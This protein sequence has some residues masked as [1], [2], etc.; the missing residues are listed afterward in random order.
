M[1]DT[2]YQ[3]IGLLLV[4]KSFC[5]PEMWLFPSGPQSFRSLTGWERRTVGGLPLPNP[6]V[7]WKISDS[8]KFRRT[9]PTFRSH[10][11]A[12]GSRD[13]PKWDCLQD[14][15]SHISFTSNLPPL[16]TNLNICIFSLA[17]LFRLW[18]P[19]AFWRNRFVV[20][21]VRHLGSLTAANWVSFDCNVS[22]SSCWGYSLIN[23]L[24]LK[25]Q[26]FKTVPHS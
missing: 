19:R 6:R 26:E 9:K 11:R 18:F 25:K 4:W 8:E 3:F 2:G 22:Y 15:P 12:F 23:T 24:K 21:S 17:S 5:Q 10:W 14:K 13:L 1:R 16:F 20:R 7:P